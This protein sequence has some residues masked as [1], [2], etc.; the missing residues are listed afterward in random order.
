MFEWGRPPPVGCKLPGLSVV[1]PGTRRR[2]IDR[3]VN[4]GARL[5]E[6]VAERFCGVA[7]CVHR[8]QQVSVLRQL[9]AVEL[10]ILRAAVRR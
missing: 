4:G 7:R 2:G 3:A 1:G 10:H 6:E 9:S 5:R 8:R